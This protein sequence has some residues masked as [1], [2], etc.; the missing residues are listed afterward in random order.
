M[1]ESQSPPIAIG[2]LGA[3]LGMIYPKT[4]IIVFGLCGLYVGFKFA[5]HEIQ[6]TLEDREE[7]LNWYETLESR[8]VSFYYRNRAKLLSKI[9]IIGR[10]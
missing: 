3:L 4:I 7:S 5:S 9:G 2:L 8:A 1:Q 10:D 6:S